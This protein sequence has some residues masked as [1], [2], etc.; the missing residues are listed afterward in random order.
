MTGKKPIAV[1]IVGQRFP[2]GTWRDVCQITLDT[3]SELD[4]DAYGRIMSA[5]PRLTGPDASVFRSARQLRNGHF[6]EVHLS[7]DAIYRFCIQATELA[8]LSSEEWEIE[9]S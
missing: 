6:I 3:I 2:V 4:P 9:T 1:R 7:A 8:E 5:Y